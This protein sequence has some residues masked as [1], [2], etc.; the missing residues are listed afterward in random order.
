MKRYFEVPLVRAWQVYRDALQPMGGLG[1]TVRG[2]S[3]SAT[4]GKV[5][6]DGVTEIAG[7]KVFALQF[8]QGRDPDW[9][10]RPFFAE[11]DPEATWLSDLRPAFGE[12][13]FFWQDGMDALRDDPQT[14]LW[15]RDESMLV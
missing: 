2:P 7:R 11:Y 13:R 14:P 9:I 4:P 1:R 3:M 12:D 15:R 10:K 5:C 8:L 6:V